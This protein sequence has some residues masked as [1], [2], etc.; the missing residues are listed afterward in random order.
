MSKATRTYVYVSSW[1]EHGGA[2]GLGLYELDGETGALAF[3]GMLNRTDSFNC[4]AVDREN[5]RLYL[6]N[7]V[8]RFPGEHAQSGRIFC[9]QIDPGSGELAELSRLTTYCPNPAWVEVDD[10][11]TWL[12]TAHHSIPAA[13]V[14]ME[15][16][17][18]GFRPCLTYP[19]ADVQVYRLGPDGLPL[20]LAE[21][22]N[23]VKNPETGEC[24]HPHCAVLSPSGELVAVCD[25]GDGC[26]Y[27]YRLD[28]ETG[29][30]ALCSRAQ[31]DQ[32][33]DS[34]RYCVFHPTLPFLYVNHEKAFRDTMDVSVFRYDGDGRTERIQIANAVLEGY[35]IP[36]DVHHE[37]QGLC[38]SPDGARLYTL[39]NGPNAVG[40]F[41]IDQASGRLTLIQNAKID[42]IRPRGLAMTPD[43]RFVLTSCLVS[44]DI[45][46]YRVQEDGTLS[47]TT[48]KAVQK[49]AS[50]L[51]F[52]QV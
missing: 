11:R 33:G 25:K 40:V 21:N 52:Y 42:G 17:E 2:P 14:R 19:E 18:E 1:E 3:R 32:D 36:G 24:G 30:L 20:A 13:I 31:T 29:A 16:T 10:T 48:G 4:S 12:L 26:L 44:G 39:L 47:R 6:C 9:F 41:A 37:Q 23:H 46:V 38:I 43:G 28:R 34:P 22:V 45:A 7:E 49:G 15:R 35:V 27:L 8:A 5:G 50:Y 51:S